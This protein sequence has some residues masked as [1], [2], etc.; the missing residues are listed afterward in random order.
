MNIH[1]GVHYSTHYSREIAASI[2]RLIPFWQSNPDRKSLFPKLDYKNAVQ[3]W[4]SVWTVYFQIRCSAGWCGV[5]T[6][7]KWSVH[8][9]CCLIRTVPVWTRCKEFTRGNRVVFPEEGVKE[10]F[11]EF[12]IRSSINFFSFYFFTFLGLLILDLLHHSQMLMTLFFL[13][14]FYSLLLEHYPFFKFKNSF[15]DRHFYNVR[16]YFFICV[17]IIVFLYSPVLLSAL[18]QLEYNL[19]KNRSFVQCLQL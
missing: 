14:Y 5:L 10:V 18:P 9:C 15:H 11:V 8:R 13:K 16:F 1:F 6:S 2:P 19:N 12:L 7:L 17:L 3:E 4:L